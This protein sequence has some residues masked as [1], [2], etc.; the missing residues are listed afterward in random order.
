[1]SDDEVTYEFVK[2]EGW[3]PRKVKSPW[4]SY[5]LERVLVDWQRHT[6]QY[7]GHEDDEYVLH[8]GMNGEVYRERRPHR[9]MTLDQFD[10]LVRREVV[11]QYRTTLYYR[12][13]DGQMFGYQVDTSPCGDHDGLNMFR[14]ISALYEAVRQRGF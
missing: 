5:N 7:L 3:V 10:R 9:T 2:G 8:R 4:T 6:Q 13:E 1:M 11:D 14:A 12:A